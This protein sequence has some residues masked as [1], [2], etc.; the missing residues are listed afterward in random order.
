MLTWCDGK[1]GKNDIVKALRKLDKVVREKGSKSNYFN[2]DEEVAEND[3]YL[4]EDDDDEN[5]VYVADGD[6]DAVSTEEEM[7]AALAS[8][9][10]VRDALR[11][12]RNGRGFYQKGKGHGGKS[13]FKG[14]GKQRVHVE[15]LK[16]RTR[17]WRCGAIGHISRECT[18]P[19]MEKNKGTFS[20]NA[21]STT[22]SSAK[23]GFF[24]IAE[25]NARG[26][27][28]SQSPESREFFWLRQ[29]VEKRRRRNF[30]AEDGAV[31]S[32][33]DYKGASAEGFCG[34]TTKSEHGVVDTAAEGG[35][36]GSRALER[37]SVKL[38]QFGLTCKKLQKRSSAKGVGQAKVLGV[39]LI[40]I[41][42]GGLNGV[43]EAT[44]VEGE[45]PLLL[46]VR[47]LRSLKVLIDFSNLSFTIPDMSIVIP[48]HELASG[49]VTIEIMEFAAGG[50]EVS[51]ANAPC[52]TADFQ[53]DP[54]VSNVGS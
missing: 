11:D 8:Y 4:Y 28:D 41:G 20:S 51:D 47:M 45:V 27:Q 39:V 50:F 19:P 6:L 42:I 3:S 15:Q 5:Y 49:H 18:N 22:N 16:L 46:P 12:Q 17:C 38:E 40:P 7:N 1:Y 10:E 25:Q 53:K 44:V 35:L 21:S 24:V 43:L 52:C 36:I 33:A 26:I 29:F 30:C 32:D 14:K 9:R 13:S 37:L 54:N 48:M 34:I 2:E 31:K 23:S